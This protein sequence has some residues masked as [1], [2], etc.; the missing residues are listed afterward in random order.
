MISRAGGQ[1]IIDM[2]LHCYDQTNY[3]VIPD[4]YGN[5]SPQSVDEHFKQTYGL[6]R[7]H[8]IVKGAI[9]GRFNA[10]NTWMDRDDDGRFIRGILMFAPGDDAG[11]EGKI[12]AQQFEE[13]VK[14]GKI[15]IFG[16][17]APVY[18]GYS[19][20][21]PGYEPYLRICE[22]YDIPVAVHTGGGPPGITSDCPNCRL[23]KGDPLLLEDVLVKFPKLRMYMLHAGIVFYERA[24]AMMHHYPQLYADLSVL[25]WVHPMLKY[26]ARDFLKKAKEFG[27]IDRVMFGSDQ[28]EWPWGIEMSI[29]YLNSLSFLSE[30]DKRG[31]LFHNAARFL[32][33]DESEISKYCIQE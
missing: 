22:K 15:E 31:I 3:Y 26:N 14:E 16:E 2:H 29:E 24:L 28:M 10:V 4:R 25:L 12:D 6:M 20:D 17:I 1:P 18:G 27:L 30:E 5:M 9:C 33:L 32:R 11:D 21:H 19:L 23:S 13:W 8:N 7:K